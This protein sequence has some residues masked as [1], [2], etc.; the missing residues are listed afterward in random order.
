MN[1]IIL[2]RCGVSGGIILKFLLLFILLIISYSQDFEQ[3]EK[4]ARAATNSLPNSLEY[5]VRNVTAGSN[6]PR[7]DLDNYIIQHSDPEIYFIGR[8][9]EHF[10][11][12]DFSA[13]LL[14]KIDQNQEKYFLEL[15][16][17]VYF[18]DL[19][20]EQISSVKKMAFYRVIVQVEGNNT[21]TALYQDKRL[22]INDRDIYNNAFYQ[23]VCNFRFDLEPDDYE[24]NITLLDSLSHERTSKKFDFTLR[25][26][27]NQDILISDME[28]FD[29]NSLNPF[30]SYPININN[31]QKY[32]RVQFD[33]FQKN[34]EDNISF[35]YEINKELYLLENLLEGLASGLKFVFDIFNPDD[36]ELDTLQGAYFVKS[37]DEK[38]KTKFM[39]H[40]F[41][42]D[43]SLFD[44]L[45]FYK[46]VRSER[47]LYSSISVRKQVSE[48]TKIKNRDIV[49]IDSVDAEK[50][51]YTKNVVGDEGNVITVIDLFDFKQRFSFFWEFIPQTKREMNL[52]IRQMRYTKDL[53]PDSLQLKY[54]NTLE[55]IDDYSQDQLTSLYNSIWKVVSNRREPVHPYI[56]MKKY[57]KKLQFASKNFPSLQ[58]EGRQLTLD[59]LDLSWHSDKTRI[60]MTYG[61]P[62]VVTGENY[63][64]RELQLQNREYM[65]YQRWDYD[66]GKQ[67]YFRGDYQIR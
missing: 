55:D 37:F 38:R 40:K 48:L 56:E 24:V 11:N 45:E 21:K 49:N 32:F 36:F 9:P 52:A 54:E 22:S 26:Y 7:G 34:L 66:N 41:N 57:Y 12:T 39:T 60:Y 13:S 43:K 8:N 14:N 62:Q 29:H 65:P 53:L 20:L 46:L 31:R 58:V 19:E 5:N 44:D 18:G 15:K 33:S 47:L 63:F 17:A 6:I 67:F 3:A 50:F 61:L 27:K 2:L 35:S 10:N 4:E 1:F 30:I 51:D 28:I 42:V 59:V 64:T 25:D 16:T 23:S